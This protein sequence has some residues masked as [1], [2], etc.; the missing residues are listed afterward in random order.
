MDQ[1]SGPNNVSDQ[2]KVN[3]SDD[4]KIDVNLPQSHENNESID[5]KDVNQ[6]ST[7]VNTSDVKDSDHPLDPINEDIST[8]EQKSDNR[9]DNEN[10][11]NDSKDNQMNEMNVENNGLNSND[12]NDSS[13]MFMAIDDDEE[14]VRIV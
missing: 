5:F 3:L 12:S 4:N 1:N 9:E 11:A 2:E 8:N 13:D 6:I 7:D 10:V 14:E